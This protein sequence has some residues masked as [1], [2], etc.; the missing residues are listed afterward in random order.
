MI[1]A[2][3]I[4]G[5]IHGDRH[6][7]QRF[8]GRPRRSQPPTRRSLIFARPSSEYLRAPVRPSDV[9]WSYRWG[10][11]G[12]TMTAR[13]R[14]KDATRDYVLKLDRRCAGAAPVL[15]IYGGKITT[16]PASGRGGARSFR[17][18][19]YAEAGLD[20]RRG[21]AGQRFSAMTACRSR[22]R[23]RWRA[24]H[25]RRGAGCG[26]VRGHGTRLER[27]L[28]D[29]ADG[30]CAGRGFRCGLERAEVRYPMKI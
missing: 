2:I 24:G 15:M 7:R 25:S 28:G 4:E 3:P 6:H 9:V 12:F 1:F 27:V 11:F 20:Q 22:S 8:P 5:E 16:Y 10:A 19:L 26:M 18:V 17:A 30:G 21:A 14:A 13:A 29:G 23:G